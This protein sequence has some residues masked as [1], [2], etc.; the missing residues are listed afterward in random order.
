MERTRELRFNTL[1][2]E[3]SRRSKPMLMRIRYENLPFKVL[4]ACGSSVLLYGWIYNSD[5]SQYVL[6]VGEFKDRV[7][8]PETRNG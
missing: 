7:R 5:L 8:K 4:K 2:V 3:K 1:R 6:W